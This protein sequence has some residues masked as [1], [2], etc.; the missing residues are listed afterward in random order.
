[1]INPELIPA[2]ISD[3]EGHI[4]AVSQSPDDVDLISLMTGELLRPL[5]GIGTPLMIDGP[6]LL[7]WQSPLQQHRLRLSRTRLP[8]PEPAVEWSSMVELPAWL[9]PHGN[10]AADF[11]LRFGRDGD[12]YALFWKGGVRHRGGAPPPLRPQG[13]MD[14]QAS[15]ERIDFDVR[16]LAVLRRSNVDGFADDD[17]HARRGEH[18]ARQA[19]GFI[20]RQAGQLHNAPWMTPEGERFVRSLSTPGEAK[21]R[22]AIARADVPDARP[23]VDFEADQLDR[24]APELSLDGQYLAVVQQLRGAAVWCVYST[25]NGEQ[26]ARVPYRDGFGAFRIFDGRLL[27]LE[28]ETSGGAN[29]LSITL[30]KILHAMNT[31]D[32]ASLWS[33]A[34]KLVTVPNRIFLPP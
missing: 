25:F 31:A 11:A 5:P 23:L 24:T 2:G 20:Y 16:T 29:S 30:R 34:L 14:R 19:R 8:P 4:G 15:C 26:I 9:T 21:Q 3:P 13:E 1:M 28:Q 33:Y 12:A 22:L 32:G 27:C 7:C 18:L 17:V 6:H 10:A